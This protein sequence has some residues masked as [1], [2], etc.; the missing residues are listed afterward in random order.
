MVIFLMNASFIEVCLQEVFAYGGR[1]TP[2]SVK[3]RTKNHCV[4]ENGE[5][6]GKHL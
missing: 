3:N 2:I 4:L 6:F 5:S 1:G